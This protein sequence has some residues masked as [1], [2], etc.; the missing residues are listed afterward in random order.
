MCVVLIAV[1][2]IGFSAAIPHTIVPSVT[3]FE[4]THD[5]NSTIVEF[6]YDFKVWSLDTAVIVLFGV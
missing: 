2:L 4:T 1:T 6:K 5:I 3:D